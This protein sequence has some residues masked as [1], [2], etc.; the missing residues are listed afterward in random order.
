MLTT[1]NCYNITLLKVTNTLNLI[2]V[3]NMYKKILPKTSENY[4]I[5][6]WEALNIPYENGETADW[7]PQVYLFS[8]KKNEKIKLYNNNEILK[9]EGISKRIITYPKYKEVYIANFPRAIVDLLLTCKDYQ[10]GNL[11]NAKNEFL[12][13]KEIKILYNYLVKLK[14]NPK[15]EEYL[16][17][18][19]T[20]K[21]FKEI[22]KVG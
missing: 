8:N 18:E 15:I 2:T 11:K 17:Y 9:N 20:T 16:K 5:S 22:K 3:K 6:G 14:N 13:K 12:N 19:F 7:H 4:Y 1:I 21:Y 10:I